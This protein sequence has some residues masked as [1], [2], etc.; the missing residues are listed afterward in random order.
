MW[1]VQSSGAV[2]HSCLKGGYHLPCASVSLSRT[3]VQEQYTAHDKLVAVTFIV[4]VPFSTFL[5]V[6][7]CKMSVSV[8]VLGLSPAPA[9][10]L[11]S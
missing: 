1:C 5:S 9:T 10:D 6:Q 2:G 4:M 11:R 8:R 7:G 3:W